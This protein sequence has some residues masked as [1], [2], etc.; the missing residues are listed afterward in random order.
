MLY[1]ILKFLHVIGA[2]VLLGTGAGIAFFM[3]AAHLSRKPEVIAGVLF[4]LHLLGM[5]S[6]AGIKEW[7]PPDFGTL[8]PLEVVILANKQLLQCSI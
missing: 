4:P 7:Q 6:L 5:K 8:Q 2:C 3:L 1:F